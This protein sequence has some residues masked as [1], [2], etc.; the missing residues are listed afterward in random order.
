MLFLISVK[1]LVNRV[2]YLTFLWMAA[3][4]AFVPWIVNHI[5]RRSSICV[6]TLT[7]FDITVPF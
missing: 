6:D 1:M 3:S 5:L 7:K 4:G 2:F